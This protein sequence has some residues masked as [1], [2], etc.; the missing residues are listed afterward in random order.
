MKKITLLLFLISLLALCA[1][2]LTSCKN[3]IN[4]PTE[5]YLDI[6]TQSLHWK[7]VRGARSYTV[8]I[9]GEPDEEVVLSNY[10]SL[11]HLEAGRYTVQVKANGDGEAISDSGWTKFEYER[12]VESGLDYVLNEEKTEYR[13]EGPGSAEGDVVI[14]LA[15]T[16]IHSNGFSLCRK[17]FNID[18]ND[19][20]LYVPREELGGKTIAEALLVPTKIYVKPVLALLEKVDVKGISHITGGGFYENIPRSIPN[21]LCAKID[22]SAVKVLPIF[23][24][25]AQFGNIPERD[26]FN[27]YN[28][29]VGMSIVVPAA[30]QELALQI[31]KEQG[32]DAYIMG[33]IIRNDEEK[34]ILE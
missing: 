5:L 19:P 30:Q 11:E 15:S 32:I 13:L 23:D 1:L 14:A 22:R 26:M 17:V 9:S 7:E 31:L 18:N 27:T 4:A 34:V 28:M 10:Y 20:L 2:T 8:K 29:G 3:S 21:G 24:L 12:P 33:S 6:E 25:I 16:G